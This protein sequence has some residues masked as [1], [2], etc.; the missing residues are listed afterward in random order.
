MIGVS[1]FL[2]LVVLVFEALNGRALANIGS[3]GLQTLLQAAFVEEIFS[4]NSWAGVA[5]HALV[6][7][8]GL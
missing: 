1:C 4:R 5:F 6:D 3:K 2:P 7:G 8:T